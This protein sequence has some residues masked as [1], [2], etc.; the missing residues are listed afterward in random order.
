MSGEAVPLELPIGLRL[1]A[2]WEGYDLSRLAPRL[3]RPEGAADAAPEDSGV[4]RTAP[5]RVR[6][7]SPHQPHSDGG[8]LSSWTNER[9]TVAQLIWGEHCLGPYDLPA[10]ELVLQRLGEPAKQRVAHLGAELGGAARLLRKQQG[11]TVSAFEYDPALLAA[12][13]LG[14]VARAAPDTPPASGPYD[15]IIVDAYADRG[16]R[17]TD[18]LRRLQPL[19]SEHGLVQLR[20]L[21]LVNERN[22]GTDAYRQWVQA[23]PIRPRLRTHEEIVRALHE[24]GLG[25]R[26][27]EDRGSAHVEQIEHAWAM[28]LDGVRVLHRSLRTRPLVPVL[29]AECE[30]WTARVQLMRSGLIAFRQYVAGRRDKRVTA[31]SD[32]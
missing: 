6:I 1:R 16:E 23:E 24:A 10:I 8:L 32:W 9:L 18:A 5:R 29:I 19:L 30:R 13:Q 21:C 11:C 12:S 27:S 4:G 3:A 7:P 20:A 26:A 25:L 17:L 31:L 22:A 28:A 14:Q 2:W 15:L